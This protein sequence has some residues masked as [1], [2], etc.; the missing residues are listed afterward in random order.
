MET[1]SVVFI[2]LVLAISIREI[3]NDAT[4]TRLM[5][6]NLMFISSLMVVIIYSDNEDVRKYKQFRD[7]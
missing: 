1:I 7:K 4:H 2:A 3:V 5:I 6:L